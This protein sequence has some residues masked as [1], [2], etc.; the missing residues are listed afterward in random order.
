MF[1]ILTLMENTAPTDCLAAEHGLSL[2]IEGGGRRVLY[3]TGGSPRFMQNAGALGAGL[4]GL[5]AGT[6]AGRLLELLS[7]PVVLVVLAGLL[8]W[9]SALPGLRRGADEK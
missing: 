1:T 4:L 9:L 8:G 7:S 3:D 2:L 5:D 6:P